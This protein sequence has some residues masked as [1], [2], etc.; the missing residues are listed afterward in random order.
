MAYELGDNIEIMQNFNF[1][2]LRDWQDYLPTVEFRTSETF[3]NGGVCLRN[4]LGNLH[5]F[6]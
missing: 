3:I 4:N 2:Y 5:P 6:R 1:F